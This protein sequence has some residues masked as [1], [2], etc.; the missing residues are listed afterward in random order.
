[1]LVRLL[2]M[3][4]VEVEEVAVDRGRGAISRVERAF[5]C[6]LLR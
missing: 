3:F 1:M 4:G 2:T 6:V 5:E